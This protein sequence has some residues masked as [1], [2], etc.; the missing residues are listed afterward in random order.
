MPRS[1]QQL[2]A[3]AHDPLQTHLEE[4]VAD[5]RGPYPTHPHGGE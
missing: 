4:F 3:I 1:L 5:A 2:D